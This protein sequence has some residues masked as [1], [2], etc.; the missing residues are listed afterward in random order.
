M[1]SARSAIVSDSVPVG[2]PDAMPAADE[3]GELRLERLD[4]RAQDVTPGL[5]HRPLALGDRGQQRLQ[6][7]PGREQRHGDDGRGPAALDGR[8]YRHRSI[9]S[10]SPTVRIWR[11][12]T[13]TTTARRR[14]IGDHDGPGAHKRLFSDLDPGAEHG[15]AADPA[16][17]AQGRP[18]ARLTR[19]VPGHRVVVGH[20]D[21]GPDEDVVLD[22]GVGGHVA[23]GLHPHPAADEHVVVDRAA[24]ADD[25]IVPHS[26]ALADVRLVARDRAGLERRPG[27]HHGSREHGRPFADHG[28][29]GSLAAGGRH[30]AEVRRLADHRAVLQD[31]A[32]IDSGAVVND[33]VVAQLHPGADLDPVADQRSRGRK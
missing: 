2:D 26:A 17:A 6:R 13:P 11:A 20:H 8:R 1:P 24:A 12:G 28:R 32:G 16:G 22:L 10:S 23:V 31:R 33:N 9:R 18:L 5:Q 30:A 4:L 7:G 27:E 14:D 29:R 25:R 19:R 21:P 15:A 3:R